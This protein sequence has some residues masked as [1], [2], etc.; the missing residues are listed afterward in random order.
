MSVMGWSS[1]AMAARCQHVVDD[2]RRGVVVQV[3]GLLWAPPLSGAPPERQQLQSA[4]VAPS[5][6][7][8]AHERADPVGDRQCQGAADDDP[9]DR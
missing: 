9:Q 4:A 1:T 2:V 8:A 5:G 3:G 6:D 7:G